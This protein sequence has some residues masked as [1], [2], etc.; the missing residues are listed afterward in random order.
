VAVRYGR[1]VQTPATQYARSGEVS[2][3]YQV[4]G[5]GER[6]L[7]VVP[8]LVSHLELGWEEPLERRFRERLASFSR[9]ILF[10][11]RGTGLSDPVDASMSIEERMDD[12]RAVLDAAGSRRATLLGFS[13]G[14]PLSVVFAASHPERVDGL[15][16]YGGFAR[17]RHAPDYPQGWTEA[18]LAE[19]RR[20]F[21]QWPRA[22][23][24]DHFAPS[25]A[26]TPR[27]Q[28]WFQRYAR[29]V[30]S[31]RMVRDLWQWVENIDVRSVLPSVRVP[32]L[33]LHRVDE[34]IPGTFPRY[35]ADNIPDAR[36]VEMPG[37]DHLM[38]IGDA[39]RLLGEVEE[40]MTGVRGTAESDRVLATVLFTDVVG[41][42]EQAAAMG[43]RAW[44]ARLEAHNQVLQRQVERFQGQMVKQTG[45]GVLALFDRPTRAIRCA[46]A[47][48]EAVERLDL[49]LRAGLHTGE[50]ERT[51]DGD[52]AGVSVH[53]G[54]RICELARAG[55]V[56]VSGTVADLV[57]GSGIVLEARDSRELRGVPGEWRIYA[58]QSKES[59]VAQPA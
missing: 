57:V 25:I 10:D 8:G 35:L 56:L 26:H 4:T 38:F 21:D 47:M 59:A 28:E 14:V 23:F 52:V 45:D 53:I 33:V 29:M 50:L 40:F 24:L 44:R 49:R 27:S 19:Y 55:E 32:T 16:L 48:R 6:D 31:P 11:K 22:D 54:A 30:A 18:Q 17:V 37:R 2:V 46:D 7:V 5:G 36:L 43:D 1:R 42:T 3:A 39:E 9:L 20:F 12:V 41:S 51:E 15:I 34:L 58:V 13:E